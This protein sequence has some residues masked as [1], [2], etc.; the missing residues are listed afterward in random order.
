MRDVFDSSAQAYISEKRKNFEAKYPWRAVTV[1]KSFAVQFDE[2][3]EKTL[4]NYS[5]R[6]G[7]KLKKKFKVI[8]HE[9]CYE[10]ACIEDNSVVE[11]QQIELPT[12]GKLVDKIG[13]QEPKQ[14]DWGFD[15]E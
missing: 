2:M 7:R 9:T 3:K 4:I 1:K 8:K 14:I 10:V 13:A 11:K 15:K 6:M 5:Y 12:R